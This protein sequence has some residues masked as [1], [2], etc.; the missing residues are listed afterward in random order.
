M[1]KRTL[2][3]AWECVAPE[4]GY[5]RWRCRNIGCA[6]SVPYPSPSKDFPK[7]PCK[8]KPRKGKP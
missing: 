8:G 5:Y 3:H 7:G 4:G 6:E 1:S 2:K